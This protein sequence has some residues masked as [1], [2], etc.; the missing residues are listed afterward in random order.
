MA[1]ELESL[2]A[3]DIVSQPTDG[4]NAWDET[5]SYQAGEWVSYNDTQYVCKKDASAGTLPTNATYWT[6]MTE[7]KK[8]FSTENKTLVNT[9]DSLMVTCH[10]FPEGTATGVGVTGGVRTVDFCNSLA[11]NPSVVTGMMYLGYVYIAEGAKDKWVDPYGRKLA[12]GAEVTVKVL[13]C[14]RSTN[15]VNIV[16]VLEMT[17]TN[18]GPRHWMTVYEKTGST[19]DPSKVGQLMFGSANYPWF[20]IL[21]SPLDNSSTNPLVDQFVAASRADVKIKD[22]EKTGTGNAVTGISVDASTGKMTVT[23][24]NVGGADEATNA[25]ISPVDGTAPTVSNKMITPKN[26]PYAV[27]Q[28]L[29]HEASETVASGM[30]VSL[31][32]EQKAKIHSWLGSYQ[33]IFKMTDGKIR[34]FNFVADE[35]E[36]AS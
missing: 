13:K 5:A 12:D 24:G 31:S 28:G 36:T 10:P 27:A 33:L 1:K 18:Q 14:E 19:T 26:A 34:T 8:K 4:A 6:E 16:M 15:Y 30:K 7:S 20:A 25:E 22:F 9:I 11:N 29:I 23:L 32:N 35:P 2:D 21:F 17:S 3:N